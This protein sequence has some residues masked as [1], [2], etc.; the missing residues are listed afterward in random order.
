MPAGKREEVLEELAVRVEQEWSG[1]LPDPDSF[2]KYPK[3]VQDHMIA[4]NDAQI[5][6]ESKRNDDLVA[7]FISDKKWGQ[8]PSFVINTLFLL[9]SFISFVITRDPVS[10]GFLSVPGVTIAVNLFKDRKEKD[11]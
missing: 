8:V 4:W 5:L 6:D 11:Q 3:H 2:V 7:A 9:A 1:L 10:F